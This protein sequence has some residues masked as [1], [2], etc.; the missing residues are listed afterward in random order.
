MIKKMLKK[1]LAARK[2]LLRKEK[3]DRELN[4]IAESEHFT[5]YGVNH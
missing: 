1:I 5:K 4:W 3:Q 2:I